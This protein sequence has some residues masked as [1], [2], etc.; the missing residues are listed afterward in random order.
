[1]QLGASR[2]SRTLGGQ[3]RVRQEFLDFL[4]CSPP[5][6]R[7]NEHEVHQMIMRSSPKKLTRD[8]R[9]LQNPQEI[10]DSQE[11]LA[12]SYHMHGV[13]EGGLLTGG[14]S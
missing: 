12:F 7:L 3:T 4:S 14:S 11:I 13:Y 9:Q 5:K 6:T 2:N 1:M 10:Q 8:S